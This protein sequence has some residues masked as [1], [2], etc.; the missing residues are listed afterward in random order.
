MDDSIRHAVSKM[1]Y[2]HFAAAEEYRK[3]IIQLGE[4]PARVFNVGALGVENILQ[5]EL[6]DRKQLAQ[7]VG[8]QAIM[9][10]SPSI[11]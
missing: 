3:R 9:Q 11:P 1:S 7:S 10:L 8:K 5:E 6:L 2:L 4:H